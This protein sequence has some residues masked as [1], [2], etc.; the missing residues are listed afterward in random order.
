MYLHKYNDCDIFLSYG[1]YAVQ[2]LV[3]K[4]CMQIEKR[5]IEAI[6]CM[7]KRNPEKQGTSLYALLVY[8]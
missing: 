5:R 3:C 4:T 2:R 1:R 8:R 7:Q 6:S